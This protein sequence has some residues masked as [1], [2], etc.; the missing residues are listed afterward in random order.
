VLI[1][2]TEHFND[3]LD[4][5]EKKATAG[6]TAAST[7]LDLITH[8]LKALQALTEPPSADTPGLRRVRQS[9]NHPVWRVSHPF[10]E[11]FAVRTIVWFPDDLTVV[12][13][14]FAN[15]K[16]RM[17][18]VFYDSVGSRADQIIDQWIRENDK[19]ADHD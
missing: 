17:G 6:D 12:V 3:M 8:E 18:D 10:R 19:E 13:A 1:D 11:G 9:R 14:L 4:D 16:A 2:W 5:L 15:D 7:V